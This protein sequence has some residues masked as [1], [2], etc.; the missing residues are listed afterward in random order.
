MNGFKKIHLSLKKRK[1]K[2]ASHKLL[3]EK[4]TNESIKNK[5]K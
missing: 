2:L 4:K 5:L 3:L 1:K